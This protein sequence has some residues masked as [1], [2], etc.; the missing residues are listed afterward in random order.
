MGIDEVFSAIND[1]DVCVLAGE[2]LKNLRLI[3]AYIR[4]Y[5]NVIQQAAS[6]GHDSVI[7]ALVRFG[8]S[9]LNTLSVC[10]R[11]PIYREAYR[12]RVS[13]AEAF[14]RLGSSTIDTLNTKGE[15]PLYLALIHNNWQRVKI[16]RMFGANCSISQLSLLTQEQHSHLDEPLDESESAKIRHRVYF[17]QSCTSRLL[18]HLDTVKHLPSLTRHL[19]K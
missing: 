6:H 9:P 14:S 8:S 19:L 5:R 13:I 10:G 18:F 17:N 4:I 16:L 15:S 11:T 7:E 12:V 3:D 2:L 1:E